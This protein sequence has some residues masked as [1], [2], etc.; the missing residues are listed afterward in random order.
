[1]ATNLRK[2]HQAEQDLIEIW[3]Y[4]ADQWGDI[5]ADKYLDHLNGVLQ[6][7]VT[8]P[9]LGKDCGHIRTG[10]RKLTVSPHAIYY[11]L[12]ENTIEIVR[13]LHQR[14]DENQNL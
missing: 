9:H 14:M 3:L 6:K 8:N 13:V 4:T 2:Q 7:L 5:Q 12:S 10:Y 11:Y 1:M